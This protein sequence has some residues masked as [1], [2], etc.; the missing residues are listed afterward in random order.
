MNTFTDVD[1]PHTVGRRLCAVQAFSLKAKT[2]AQGEFISPAQV[3]C[4]RGE[5]ACGLRNPKRE[6]RLCRTS[7]FGDPAGTRTPDLRLKR[8]LLYQLS[9]WVIF[10]CCLHRCCHASP[11]RD[12]RLPF[13]LGSGW[14]VPG[15]PPPSLRS[16]RAARD[17][18][19]L[20]AGM[21]GLEPTNA[22]VKV[23]CLTTWLH[24]NGMDEA[25]AGADA[26]ALSHGMGWIMGLEPT[27]P[28]TTIR[29]SAN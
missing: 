17:G 9:Y 16:I 23:P 13:D 29:C 3:K 10:G 27:T 24:P 25:R 18:S 19:A 21:V 5:A 26:P 15:L 11:A 28:G 20:L 6:V 1:G 2:L 8:A 14:P 7:L 4:R 22:G 12:A